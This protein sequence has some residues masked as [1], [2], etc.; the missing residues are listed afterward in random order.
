MTIPFRKLLL[1]PAQDLHVAEL[2]LVVV[3]R[4]E[5]GDV[6]RPRRIELPIRIPNERILDTADGLAVYPM[7]LEMR[8]GPQ[9]ISIGVRDRLARVD[10]TI[11]LEIEVGA[12]AAGSTPPE[13][14]LRRGWPN[15]TEPAAAVASR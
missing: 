13:A 5:A 11:T 6:S 10:S 3:A 8:A 12:G 1:I 7:K 9:R 14:R 4:D 2:T 15:R